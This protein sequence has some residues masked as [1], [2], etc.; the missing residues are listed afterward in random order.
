ME[1]EW[2]VSLD[3]KFYFRRE[4]LVIFVWFIVLY[5]LCWIG[6]YFGLI[7]GYG[8]IITTFGILGTLASVIALLVS[9]SLAKRKRWF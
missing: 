4:L 6:N 3:K 5:V 2:G 7:D 1:T 9:M 8:E